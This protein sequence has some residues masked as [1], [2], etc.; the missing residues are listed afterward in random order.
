M[1][2]KRLLKKFKYRFEKVLSFKKHL[3]TQKQRD[4]A[5][6]VDIEQK[7]KQKILEVLDDRSKHQ[8]QEKKYLTGKINSSL[9]A[10]YS[11]YYTRLKQMEISGR[12]L[13]VNIREEAEK[14]RKIL[15]EATKQRKIYDKLKDRHLEKYTAEMNLL[16][17]KE[18]DDIGQT[19][20][21]RNK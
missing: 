6:V 19:M 8:K 15:V 4:L 21:L 3:E 16:I 9:L 14:R 20:Y 5:E 10:R 17:Q 13:L 18:N 12:E 11:R 1:K 2:A 7:Q